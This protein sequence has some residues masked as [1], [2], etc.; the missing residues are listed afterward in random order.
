MN[1]FSSFSTTC[2]VNTAPVSGFIH[3]LTLL[4]ERGVYSKQPHMT[5]VNHRDVKFIFVRMAAS[6]QL[7]AQLVIPK[8]I[9]LM[10]VTRFA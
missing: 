5:H 6:L 7:R 2:E 9:H 4:V 8:A 10:V 1:R 3:M